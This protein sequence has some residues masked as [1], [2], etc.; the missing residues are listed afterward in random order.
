MLR[1]ISKYEIIPKYFIYMKILWS[2]M[3][4]K[5]PS[6]K[7]GSVDD[8]AIG[9]QIRD[10]RRAKR[11]TLIEMADRIGRSTGNISEIE[12]GKSAVTIPVLQEIAAA[13]DVQISWFFHSDKN[14]VAEERDFIVRK[15]NR[16]TLKL[17]NA[18]LT[19][20]LLSPSLSGKLEFLLTTYKPGV[21]TGDQE[22]FRQGEE[23]GLILAG[24]LE[25]TTEDK[26]FTLEKGDSFSLPP[27]GSHRSFNPGLEDVV[28]AW[29]MTPP[30]F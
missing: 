3:K 22:R 16:K 12:R 19:E 8:L 4:N 2:D 28:I 1:T 17:Q 27:K 24:T 18:G 15:Q 6:S 21:G 14:T 10:L 5:S 9:H 11:I 23:A 7:T 25:L 20:E 13:L 26:T 29:V 30:A